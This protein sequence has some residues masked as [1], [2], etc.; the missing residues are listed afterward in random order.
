M[1]VILL[2]SPPFN[3]WGNETSFSSI[4]LSEVLFYPLLPSFW[5]L[6]DK[7]DFLSWKPSILQHLCLNTQLPSYHPTSTNH[8]KVSTA[9]C[10][11]SWPKD[12]SALASSLYSG[13]HFVF[14]QYWDIPMSLVIGETKHVVI[15]TTSSFIGLKSGIF[16]LP[17]IQPWNLGF[18]LEKTL[19]FPPPCS[20]FS[21]FSQS[22]NLTH[23]FCVTAVPLWDVCCHCHLIILTPHPYYPHSRQVGRKNFQQKKSILKIVTIL[24]CCRLPEVLFQLWVRYPNSPFSTSMSSPLNVNNPLQQPLLA[25]WYSQA[26]HTELSSPASTSNP[27]T[28]PRQ[29]YFFLS[30]FPFQAVLFW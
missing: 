16:F 2:L 18:Q 13:T 3:R 5:L 7:Q 27:V 14:L 24:K 8:L 23:H 20:S 29:L 9:L 6:S 25:Y 11:T 22:W 1:F 15:S 19:F 30:L 12:H 28:T 21:T 26:S 17:V 10:S 4:L